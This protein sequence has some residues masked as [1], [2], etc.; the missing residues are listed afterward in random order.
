MS[1]NSFSSFAA[2][3][4]PPQFT[5]EVSKQL[6]QLR[7][8][9]VV[10][11][12][13]L[14]MYDYAYRVQHYA[15]YAESAVEKIAAIKGPTSRVIYGIGFFYYNDNNSWKNLQALIIASKAKDII[16]VIT[17]VLSVPSA[18]K[19]IAMPPT[20]LRSAS[21]SPPRFD[22]AV[23]MAEEKF[24]AQSQLLAF[25]FQMGTLIYNMTEEYRLP[26]DALYKTCTG[27]IVTDSSQIC[28][29][30]EILLTAEYAVGSLAAIQYRR[31]FYTYDTAGFV[32]NSRKR[33]P[34]FTWFLF[35]VH[36]TDISKK[37]HPDGPFERLKE[38]RKFYLNISERG[39]R[40]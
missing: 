16:V 15:P 20:A 23:A 31:L 4:M 10:H 27:F 37:C 19:C 28:E 40:R 26:T 13:I 18:T 8:K 11:L 29:R 3:R 32:M 12:G 5:L 14:N 2:S 22:R 24:G 39:Y 34:E 7:Q 1:E 30:E 6:F 38:F 25:S 9:N 17:S 21:D 33:R 35:N 36:L